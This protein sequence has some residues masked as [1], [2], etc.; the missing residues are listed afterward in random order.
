MIAQLSVHPETQLTE[1]GWWCTLRLW[2][3]RVPQD[4]FPDAGCF[5]KH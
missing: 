2:N 3:D 5:E 4:A 1:T